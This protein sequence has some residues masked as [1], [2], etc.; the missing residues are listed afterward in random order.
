M[1]DW[2]TRFSV[3]SDTISAPSPSVYVY[4]TRSFDET[5]D[6]MMLKYNVGD[7]MLVCDDR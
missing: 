5:D 2:M 6:E 3:T 1:I 4:G 7:K